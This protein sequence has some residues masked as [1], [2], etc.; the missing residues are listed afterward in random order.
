MGKEEDIVTLYTKEQKA[1]IEA[2]KESKFLALDNAFDFWIHSLLDH[3]D[4]ME[5]QIQVFLFQ[6]ETFPGVATLALGT[7]LLFPY[8]LS[9][10]SLA[11][12]ASQ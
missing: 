4:D 5:R 1:P 7:T 11:S 12:N 9:F 8:L 6:R 2:N 3:T 10:L